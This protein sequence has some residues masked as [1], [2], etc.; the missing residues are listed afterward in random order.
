MR[1]TVVLG[2][3]NR[4][5]LVREAIR[6]VLAQTWTDW[7]LVVADDGSG[8]E[9]QAAILEELATRKADH[10]QAVVLLTLDDPPSSRGDGVVRAVRRIN[11]AIPSVDG[12]IVHYLADDDFF[13]SDRLA[14]FDDFFVRNP[15][16]VC[17]YGG[18]RYVDMAGRRVGQIR[19]PDTVGDP[20][21]VLDQ[22][23][24]A[25]RASAFERV[26]AWP[27]TGDYT[28]DGRFM[29]ALFEA[30]G[31]FGRIDSFVH[32]KRLHDLNMDRTRAS[33]T[34]QRE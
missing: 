21:C 3:Y 25:H 22:G 24:F 34:S 15:D 14:D 11:D 29:R 2:S 7:Q 23:Q 33:T 5:R 31:R 19:F 26:P 20:W 30:Y 27:A 1:H 28:D 4:P 12:E 8:P 13:T 17:A 10:G 16:V 32:H 9:T 6:S 18:L